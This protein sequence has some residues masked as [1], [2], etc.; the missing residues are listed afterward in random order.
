MTSMNNSLKKAGISLG[1]LALTSASLS[2]QEN[3]LIVKVGA[4]YN[5]V[6]TDELSKNSLGI[7]TLLE[8]KLRERLFAEWEIGLY[9]DTR[10]TSNL[11][12]SKMQTNIGLE[13]KPVMKNGWAMGGKFAIGV[14]SEFYKEIEQITPSKRISLNKLVGLDAEKVFHSGLGVNLGVSR[15]IDKNIWRIGAKV[16]LKSESK[17]QHNYSNR[18]SYP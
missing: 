8:K 5:I 12:Y 10:A 6:Q 3:P 16:I 9:A 18:K 4:A 7:E 14:S 15:E 11:I 13:Y 1:L 2:A 17:K